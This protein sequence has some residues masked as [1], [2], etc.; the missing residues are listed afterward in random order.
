[1]YM[2]ISKWEYYPAHEAELRASAAKMMADL[3][4]WDG[5]EFAY[6]VRAS[7]SEILAVIAYSDEAS[8][9]R[10]IQDPNGP[11]AKAA[12]EHEIER[13]SQWKWSERGE[14]EAP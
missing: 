2:V 11:F 13:Y 4:S 8:Y 5:V 7:P 6:N 1:M 14:V 12:A 9:N 3:T 10:L